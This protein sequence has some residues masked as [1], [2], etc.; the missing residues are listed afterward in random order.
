MLPHITKGLFTTDVF[1]YHNISGDQKNLQELPEG[2]KH[3]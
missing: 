3:K 1:N 2:N